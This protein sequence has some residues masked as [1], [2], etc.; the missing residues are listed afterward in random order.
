MKILNHRILI[1]FQI[2]NI[3]IYF[4]KVIFKLIFYIIVKIHFLRLSPYCFELLS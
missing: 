2:L 3:T 4:S 1:F